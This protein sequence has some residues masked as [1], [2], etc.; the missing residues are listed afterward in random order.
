MRLRYVQNV[1]DLGRPHAVIVPGTKSTIADLVWLR[2]RGLDVAIERLARD[3][4]AIAGICGGFQMLGQT[5]RDPEQVESSVPVMPGL[6]LLPVE[7]VF[8]PA[9]ITQQVSAQV[10]AETGWLKSVRA[11][12]LEGYE[13]HMGRTVGGQPW[14]KILPPGQEARLDGAVSPDGKIW[15]CY[16]H[17]LFANAGFRRAWLGSLTDGIKQTADTGLAIPG[18][19]DAALDKLADAVEASL[20]MERLWDMCF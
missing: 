19:L 13:I 12:N 3:G 9:K 11:Q 6:G 8:A 5:L 16:L 2:A 18:N 7:T 15:G 14:L 17:G 1:H 4:V 20:D 10:I